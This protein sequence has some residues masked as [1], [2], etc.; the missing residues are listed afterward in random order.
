[1]VS[2]PNGTWQLAKTL[3]LAWDLL[4]DPFRAL[5]LELF[6]QKPPAYFA[7]LMDVRG[8]I[9]GNGHGQMNNFL[10]AAFDAKPKDASLTIDE[11]L[12]NGLSLTDVMFSEFNANKRPIAVSYR[13]DEHD[14][15]I[16]IPWLALEPLVVEKA[17]DRYLGDFVSRLASSQGKSE[18]QLQAKLDKTLNGYL[19]HVSRGTPS[20]GVDGL[21]GV[22]MPVSRN[23]S[24]TV[25]ICLLFSGST[26]SDTDT[27]T[28]SLLLAKSLEGP[29]AYWNKLSTEFEAAAQ[30]D[31]EHLIDRAK[32]IFPILRTIIR[33]VGEV[34]KETRDLA[35]HLDQHVAS[36]YLSLGTDVF[37]ELFNQGMHYWYGARNCYLSDRQSDEQQLMISTFHN[38]HALGD[39]TLKK[40]WVPYC[41]YYQHVGELFSYPFLRHLPVSPPIGADEKVWATDMW[42]LF[43]I[44]FHRSSADSRVLY[45][46]QLAV[47]ARL[48]S[49][50]SVPVTIIV[51][52]TSITHDFEIEHNFTQTGLDG[53]T[54]VAPRMGEFVSA[55]AGS[56]R[57]KHV[58]YFADKATKV[59]SLGISNCIHTLDAISQFISVQVEGADGNV[60]AV[61]VKSDST[62][63]TLNINLK[64]RVNPIAMGSDERYSRHDLSECLRVIENS[65]KRPDDISTSMDGA[66]F[67][68]ADSLLV[69]WPRSEK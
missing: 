49:G 45:D 7:L 59:L 41:K 69:V 43:K 18:S 35:R 33:G 2:S 3:P 30:K 29:F 19:Q 16:Q 26:G 42:R 11:Y 63:C 62:C 54:Y 37:P 24:T 32:Q 67:E 5:T 21:H 53:Y 12:K 38:I 64:K 65:V 56:S 28:R 58:D 6:K 61:T 34:N 1:M 15:A 39:N 14:S 9:H 4:A 60:T 44:L 20:G 8:L 57:F 48:A 10:F 66:T 40:A 25:A 36:H 13:R 23:P 47:V 31:A 52:E 51:T 27:L 46:A 55:L 22:F 68:C 50:P 17:G